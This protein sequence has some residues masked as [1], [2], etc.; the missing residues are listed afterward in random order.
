VGAVHDE[1]EEE[2][3]NTFL[4]IMALLL[5]WIVCEILDYRGGVYT[6]YS[7]PACDAVL[8]GINVRKYV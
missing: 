7:V 3:T 5:S 1:T 6:H 2:W 8:P 4:H